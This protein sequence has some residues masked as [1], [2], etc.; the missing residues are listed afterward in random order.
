[1][2]AEA[3][4]PRRRGG[5]EPARVG[6][7]RLGDPGGEAAMSRLGWGWEEGTGKEQAGLADRREV[8]GHR[9]RGSG[10]GVWG[11]DPAFQ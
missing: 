9:K 3:G 6:K 7:R 4:R 1:M 10:T 8:E 5:D 11:Q 2:K